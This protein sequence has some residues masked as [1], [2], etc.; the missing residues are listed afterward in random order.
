VAFFSSPVSTFPS[1]LFQS[2]RFK[3]SN[4]QFQEPR[5]MYY[6]DWTLE[7][8]TQRRSTLTER[9]RLVS[10]SHVASGSTC[11]YVTHKVHRFQ[12]PTNAC[13]V[14]YGMY[15]ALILPG[16]RSPQTRT[17]SR[18]CGAIY[19]SPLIVGQNVLVISPEPDFT[20]GGSLNI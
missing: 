3:L 17:C 11:P 19:T 4:F 20:E 15:V 7:L 2:S 10:F 1:S 6:L 9:R 18:F 16:N 8:K 14:C 12:L 13:M 5:S